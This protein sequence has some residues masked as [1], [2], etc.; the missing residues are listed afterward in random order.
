VGVIG[1]RPVDFYM[2]TPRETIA[3]INSYRQ[4]E[5]RLT[6]ERWTQARLIGYWSIIG[7]GCKVKPG[8]S[9]KS[10]MRFEW[11]TPEYIPM[12]KEQKALFNKWHK[13]EEGQ[14]ALANSKELKGKAKDKALSKIFKK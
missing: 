7:G 5:D 4:N 3:M 1:V 8:F 12:T 10:L 13:S 6:R 14:K 2:M 9:P 11:D